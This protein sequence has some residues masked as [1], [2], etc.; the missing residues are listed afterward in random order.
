MFI[1]KIYPVTDDSD[2][3]LSKALVVGSGPVVATAAGTPGDLPVPTSNTRGQ[4]LG[5]FPGVCRFKG[6][7]TH[8]TP[9]EGSDPPREVETADNFSGLFLRFGGADETAVGD[10]L[11][12]EDSLVPGQD[13]A[14]LFEGD[15]ND[16][17]VVVVPAVE[18]VE[19]EEPEEGGKPPEMNVEDEGG[20]AQRAA[21]NPTYALNV[22]TF[23]NRVDGNAVP[24]LNLIREVDGLAIGKHQVHLGVGNA[25]GLDKILYPGVPDELAFQGSKTLPLG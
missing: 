14:P 6:G 5:D 16:L 12:L 8:Q 2:R 19:A 25:E 13:D 11:S 21:P 1:V 10:R 18:R 15:S 3:C 24:F 7:V 17:W 22:E 20:P 4:L 9:G 23:E